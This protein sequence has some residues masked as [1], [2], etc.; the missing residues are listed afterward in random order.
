MEEKDKD[1]NSQNPNENEETP[2]TTPIN[3]KETIKEE[4]QN[5][6]QRLGVWS[7]AFQVIKENPL[8]GVGVGDGDQ[9]LYQHYIDNDLQDIEEVV[10]Q[11]DDPADNKAYDFVKK[12][13]FDIINNINPE[14]KLDTVNLMDNLNNSF[15]RRLLLVL[16]LVFLLSFRYLS[17]SLFVRLNRQ[18]HCKE[19]QYNFSKL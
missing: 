7:C 2:K 4:R 11:N 12:C 3:Q 8:F 1:P 14:Y 17:S 10:I 15:H 5:V 19:Y 13:Y 18:L 6:N 9:V 16:H